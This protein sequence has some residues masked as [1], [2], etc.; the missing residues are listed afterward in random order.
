M[1]AR[2]NLKAKFTLLFI[3]IGLFPMLIVSII[4]TYSSTQD[5]KNKVYNQ[6]TAINQIKKKS[7]ETYFNERKGD[8]AVLVDIADTLSSQAFAKLDAVQDIK[9][10]QLKDYLDNNSTQL[11]LLSS[12]ASVQDALVELNLSFQQG[13]TWQA[14][15]D[16]YDQEYTNLLDYFGWYDF[17][18]INLEGDI[19]YSVTRE[20]DLGQNLKN[21]LG[22]SSFHQAFEL[23]QKSQQGDVEFAD[24]LPYA[25]SNNDPAAFAVKAVSQAGQR[26]GYLAYQ[27]PLEKINEILGHRTGMGDTGESYLVGQDHFMRSDSYLNPQDY[28]VKA[29]FAGQNKVETKAVLNALAGEKGTDITLDYNHNP[30]LSSWDYLDV[31]SNIRWAMISEID[32]AEAL[33]PQTSNNTEFY[34]HYIEQYGYYD[35]FLI[36]PDGF[37]FYTVTK[38]ADYHTNILDGKFSSSNLGELVRQVNQSKAY[39]FIDFAPYAP[40]NGDPA[41]F[42]A[43]PIQD[44]DGKVSLYIALQL[45][46]EG[47]ANI[48]NVRE[49]MGVTGESYLVGQDLKMRSDSFLDAE[50]HSVKASFAGTVENN[51]V[52]TSA[53]KKALAGNKGA[54]LIIDYNG[55]PVLSSYDII[56]F[57]NFNWAVLSEID[58]AEAFASIKENI[59]LVAAIMLV[60]L[61]FVAFIGYIVARR[62]STP[63]SQVSDIAS[64]IAKGNLTSKVE[65]NSHDEVG[66]LQ[67]A[68]QQ[69]LTNLRQMVGN[70]SHVASKQSSTSEELAAVTTQT[71]STMAEQQAFSTELTNAMQDMSVTLNQ[72][73]TNTQDTSRAVSDISKMVHEGNDKLGSTYQLI[74]SMSEQIAQSEQR[75]Q[76][77]RTDFNQVTGMLDEIKGIA[78][79]TNLL[80]LNAAIEAARAGEQG[81]GFAVVAD[82]VRQLAQ[83]TQVSTQQIDNM[84]TQIIE[85]ADASVNVMAQSVQQAGEV[86]DHAKEVTE[87][88]D[89]ISQSMDNIAELSHFITTATQDQSKVINKIIYD[90]ESLNTGLAETTSA[91]DNIASSSVELTKLAAN[92]EKETRFFKV[93]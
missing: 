59:Y 42:I 64:L 84:I 93:E 46:L 58:E 78:E 56:Q 51:G 5:A 37:I 72:V 8:M 38:E 20:N 15:L 34:K 32:V 90:V 65:V 6:L 22:N 79:Q 77:V 24:F 91:T 74:L 29:S 23:A 69:M 33:N 70:I 1:K 18:L 89:Q 88:N 67:T 16:K 7:L 68:M 86:K 28:S 52:D 25:P 76:R 21:D 49:G 47:I 83:R 73:T 10:A 13:N 17:F 85:G 57:D 92:L 36:N 55:N 19:V 26:I 14:S 80:A 53:T 66:D 50:G 54:D 60:S 9:K 81:R 11:K 75:V 35:L 30:V 71:S 12:Q 31:G 2:L 41:A 4:T 43:Q 48:M 62:L 3:A 82:E 61:F 44:K 45:P 39:G 27:Q 87:I 40:S 63:I